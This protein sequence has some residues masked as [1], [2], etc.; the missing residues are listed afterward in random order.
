MLEDT[1]VAFYNLDYPNKQLVLLDDTRYDLPGGDPA[2]L[3]AYGAEIEALCTRLKV[4]LFRRRW[5]GAKAGIVNDFLDFTAGRAKEGSVY[6]PLSGKP[7]PPAARYIAIFDADQ[8]PFPNF[9]NDLV[10]IMERN[11]RMAFVQTPQVYTNTRHNRVSQAAALQQSVFY[12]YICEGK[13]LEN[14]MFCC[15]TNVLFRIEALQ[16]VGGFDESSVTEDFATSWKFHAAGWE[17]LYYP[18]ACAFGMGPEDLGSYFKQQ[19]R[20]ALGTVGQFG[21]VL[22]SLWRRPGLFHSTHWGEYLLSCSYYL[23]GFA[24]LILVSCPILYLFFNVPTYFANPEL[25][26]AFFVPY[27]SLS[28]GLFLWTLRQRHYRMKDLM[29]G[30]L[31]IAV[32]FPVYIKA[33]LQALIG[34]K[35][36]FVVTPKGVGAA[37]PIRDIWPQL[38]LLGINAAAVVWGLNRLWFEREPVGALVVN[39]L[40]AVYHCALL[41]SVFYFNTPRAQEE[42]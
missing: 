39:T 42:I 32:S 23:I 17:S 37:L 5:R 9:L 19:F 41:S 20:W 10:S 35:G 22:A 6:R 34:I 36:R 1:L 27:F 16:A 38:L 2:A 33:S 7:L 18:R 31:L 26:I 8:N 30:Q 4:D 24:F 13:G 25:Y 3:R 28:M 12:E 15:G 40:W 21:R 11:P 29:L 14:A